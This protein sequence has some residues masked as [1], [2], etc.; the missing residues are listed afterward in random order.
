MFRYHIKPDSDTPIYR[1]LVDQINA[2]IRSGV[3]KTGTQLPTVREMAQIT[4][5]S[6]GT[7]KRVYDCLQEMGDIEMTRRRGTFVKYVSQGRDS[8]KIQAMNAIDRMI[9]Q[10]TDLNFSPAE[11]QI[12]INL[13]MREW[14]LKWSGVRIAVAEN[15]AECA[16]GIEDQLSQI[17]NVSVSIWP[18]SQIREYPYGVDEQSD[19]ILTSPE[20]HQMLQSLLPDDEKI[21]SVAMEPDRQFLFALANVREQR[22]GILCADAAFGEVVK[23]AMPEEMRSAVQ[24]CAAADDQTA[25]AFMD[26]IG[27]LIVS[28]DYKD[29]FSEQLA[30]KIDAFENVI[31]FRYLIDRGSMLYLQERIGRIRDERQLRPGTFS[32]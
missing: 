23:N 9:R 6:C 31:R 26:S 7:I 21:I 12:F 32:F 3:L 15:C 25:G 24:L 4:Q 28:E 27:C 18:M 5:L 22:I 17:G 11:I 19:V 30:E 2:E 29:N 10:L 13:K 20:N 8:R 1:Q 16:A 14:G